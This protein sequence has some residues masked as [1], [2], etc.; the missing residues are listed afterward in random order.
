VS[1]LSLRA[2]TDLSRR[3]NLRRRNGRCRRNSRRRLAFT[4]LELMI[5]VII[6]GILAFLG[7]VSYHKVVVKTK[8][9]KAKHAIALIAEAEKMYKVDNGF[10]LPVVADA[11]EAT[12]G[13]AVTGMNL[14][15]VDNDTIFTY[16]ATAAGVVRASNTVV[17]GSCPVGTLITFDISTGAIDIPACYE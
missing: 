7:R 8:T 4:I 10:Y 11:V 16:S 2:I 17:I 5:T 1:G 3:R 12:I 15:V 14:A 9:G 13:T 6:V